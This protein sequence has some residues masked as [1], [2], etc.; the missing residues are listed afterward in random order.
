MPELQFVSL[1]KCSCQQAL[2]KGFG[3]LLFGFLWCKGEHSPACLFWLIH[4]FGDSKLVEAVTLWL[5]VPLYCGDF[6]ALVHLSLRD[7][8]HLPST[9]RAG[10]GCTRRLVQTGG[11]SIV[12]LKE[13]VL[14]G[15]GGGV[16]L[17][18]G[19]YL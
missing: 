11:F 1:P 15:G 9:T 4:G 10:T 6:W 2:A 5:R 19:N 7:H 13:M 14:G 12:A 18:F 3:F 8:S 16:L 17:E